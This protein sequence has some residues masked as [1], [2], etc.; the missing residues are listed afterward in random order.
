MVRRI[1]HLGLIIIAV[2]WMPLDAA[3]DCMAARSFIAPVT[4]STLPAN[5]VLYAFV[6][7]DLPTPGVEVDAGGASVTA[8]IEHLSTNDT[9]KSYR[10]TIE[11]AV[12]GE[13]TVQVLLRVE[14]SVSVWAEARYTLDPGWQK[15]TQ[16]R[17]CRTTIVGKEQ[18]GWTCSHNMT[19][20]LEPSVQAIAYRLEWSTSA[21]DHAAGKR[22]SAV[23]PAS[24]DGFFDPKQ[25]GVT[26]TIKLGHANCLSNTFRWPAALVYVGL[27]ALHQ[28]GSETPAVGTPVQVPWSFGDHNYGATT[29]A[30]YE[31]IHGTDRQGHPR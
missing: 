5:P 12:A 30:F 22:D 21:E 28:D 6:P 1:T 25:T 11:R 2:Q 19:Y 10:I 20:N 7:W 24:L 4:G 15:A 18:S 26:P 16:D 3:A 31:E 8:K 13:I 23:F 29:D 17:E 14:D 9:F 27:T